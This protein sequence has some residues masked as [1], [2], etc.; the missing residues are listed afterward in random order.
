VLQVARRRW[1]GESRPRIALAAQRLWSFA[2]RVRHG[3]A[4]PIAYALETFWCDKYGIYLQGWLHC[5]EHPVE[6]LVIRIGGDSRTITEFSPRADLSA[7]V[8]DGRA[9]F[10]AYVPASPR[11][12]VLL[13]VRTS[14]GERTLA[15]D[16]PRSS[17][18]Q[19]TGLPAFG[20]FAQELNR[21]RGVVVEIG[22]R[23]VSPGAQGLRGWFPDV[24]RYIGVDVHPSPNV[25]VVG[26]AHRL[27]SLVGTE[28][29]D[30]VFSISVLEHLTLPWVAAGEI[31]RVLRD[32]GWVFHLTHQTWP[33]HEQPNDFWRFSDEGLKVL[34]G[35]LTGFT[36]VEAGMFNRMDIYPEIRQ[37]YEQMPLIPGWGGAYVLAQKIR[38]LP[39]GM[40][41]WAIDPELLHRR[42]QEYPDHGDAADVDWPAA[43]AILA[44]TATLSNDGTVCIPGETGTGVFAVATLNVGG[45]GAI[46]VSAD[47]G[48]AQLP[49]SLA[50]CQTDPETGACLTPPSP[51]VTSMVDRQA[52]PTFGVFVGGAGMV[53]FDPQAN[54]VFVRFKSA[55]GVPRG[56]TSVAVRTECTGGPWPA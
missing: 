42:S 12:P 29:V 56:S 37:G 33:V 13:T 23:L 19:P 1:L 28:A 6:Q 45:A 26:D 20:R 2:R 40:A 30:G 25:D 27:A 14:A 8:P 17:I 16:L 24:E 44:L 49:V 31:N 32:G 48:A 51:T 15:V 10:A 43:P 7:V 22:A 53:P 3:T 46:A 34:F 9:G 21:R 50:V 38:H 47:T 5:Y 4:M 41:G 54:R 39:D 52:T 35:P 18:S 55:D 11:A 36:V